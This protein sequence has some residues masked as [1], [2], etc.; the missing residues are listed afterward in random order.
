MTSLTEWT[1]DEWGNI[2]TNTPSNGSTGETLVADIQRAQQTDPVK[3]LLHSKKTI[4][5]NV[6]PGCTSRAQPLDVVIDKPFKNAIKEN[7][8]KR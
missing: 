5:V 4:F 6:P 3:R 8:G 7:F 1:R 2:F